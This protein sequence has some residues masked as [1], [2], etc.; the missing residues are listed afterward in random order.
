MKGSSYLDITN[1]E[2]FYLNVFVTKD[3]ILWEATTRV[4]L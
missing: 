2:H 3:L 1:G 4:Y